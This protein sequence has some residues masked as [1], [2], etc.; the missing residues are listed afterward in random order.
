MPWEMIAVALAVGMTI[1]AGLY[2]IVWWPR[3]EPDDEPASEPAPDEP[4]PG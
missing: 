3:V 2:F 4:A 1:S